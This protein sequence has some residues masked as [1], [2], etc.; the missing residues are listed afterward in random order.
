[1][2]VMALV[3]MLNTRN[4]RERSTMMAMVTV[5]HEELER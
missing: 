2:M 5:C 4:M 3:L 1:M